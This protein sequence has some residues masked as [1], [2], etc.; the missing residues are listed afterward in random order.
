LTSTDT[1]AAFSKDKV[2]ARDHQGHRHRAQLRSLLIGLAL[3][4]AVAFTAALVGCGD[5]TDDGEGPRFVDVFLSE[6]EVDPEMSSLRSGEVRFTTTNGGT[7]GHDL[8]V[9]N[10]DLAVGELPIREDGSVDED[11]VDVVGR[12]PTVEPGAFE[13]VTLSLVPGQYALI[14]NIV[15][16]RG[17]ERTSHY[18]LGMH[19]SIVVAQ[20]DG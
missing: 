12:V 11:S 16:L 6:W 10:T 1:I 2:L 4:F 3:T 14:C 18:E 9:I 17:E 15:D 5:D 7:I 13:R 20:A 8:V 19:T